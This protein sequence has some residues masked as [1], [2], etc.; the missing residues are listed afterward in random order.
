MP[1]Q[2]DKVVAKAKGKIAAVKARSD[3]LRGVFTK[4]AEQHREAIALLSHLENVSDLEKRRELWTV[5]RKALVSHERAEIS[6]VYS[7]LMRYEATRGIASQHALEAGRLES[8]L[9]ELDGL[10][11]E[12]VSWEPKFQQLVLTLKGHI[13]REEDEFFPVG[14][15]VLG[16]DTVK[17][18][19]DAYDRAQERELGRI[20]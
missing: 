7:V 8:T 18:L 12:D 20:V 5:I 19:E 9:D 6:E 16:E 15:E 1:N 10:S 13:G 3:G 17:Q 11:F 14:Q 2:M 4:L